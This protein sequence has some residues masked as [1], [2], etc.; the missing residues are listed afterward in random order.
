[1]FDWISVL[2]SREQAL[3]IWVLLVAALSATRA[4][5]RAAF[6]PLLRIALEPKLA[7]LFLAAGAYT[8]G[9]V[10]ASAWRGAWHSSS[11]KET[12][13]WFC[14][15]TVVLL[16]RAPDASR[17]PVRLRAVA[18]SAL[19]LTIIVEFLLNLYVFPLAIELV[20]IPLVTLIVMMNTVAESQAELAAARRFFTGLMVTIG[21]VLAAVAVA[22]AIGSPEPL[23][24]RV[25]IEALLVP[26]A[27]TL[28][29]LPFLY[30]FMLVSCYEQIFFRIDFFLK[31]DRRRARRL[32]WRI[33]RAF[34]LNLYRLSVFAQ[35]RVSELHK[36]RDGATDDHLLGRYRPLCRCRCCL[37]DRG[38]R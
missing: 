34:H 22:R 10:A 35:S 11:L 8:A 16:V 37:A 6:R 36:L 3:A 7:T 27:L 12:I 20:I 17:E 5:V 4:D 38:A 14:G 26:P 19:S 23:L 32:K 9:V 18:R 31:G 1:M 13:Y 15:A 29:F 2:D 33:A 25:N 30:L 21:L 24:T 28:T